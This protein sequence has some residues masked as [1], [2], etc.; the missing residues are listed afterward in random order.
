MVFFCKLS[1][2]FGNYLWH[3]NKEKFAD[4]QPY[5]KC[6]SVGGSHNDVITVVVN[7]RC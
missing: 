6:V 1:E 7:A 5:I 3:T 4:H 2:H